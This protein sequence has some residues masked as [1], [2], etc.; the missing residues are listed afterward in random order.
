MLIN[1]AEFDYRK[2]FWVT[3]SIYIL[4]NSIF[5]SAYSQQKLIAIT[6]IA[7]YYILNYVY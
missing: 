2:R 3:P 1:R 4:S 7:S 6:L 5:E